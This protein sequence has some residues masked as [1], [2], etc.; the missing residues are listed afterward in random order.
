[1]SVYHSKLLE[2]LSIE[3]N[4][5]KSFLRVKY[6]FEIDIELL[7]EID[8]ETAM[9]LKESTDFSGKFKY[10]MSFHTSWNSNIQQH[11]S[12]ITRTYRDNS[13]KI[14][15]SCSDEYVRG[16][17]A[18][19]HSK[20]INQILNDKL[21]PA[22]NTEVKQEGE[23]HPKGKILNNRKHKVAWI[24]VA[25][26]IVISTILLG[27][28]NNS[29]FN[30]LSS[31]TP[32]LAE[33]V[34]KETIESLPKNEES[35]AKEEIKKNQ[36]IISE[37]PF[38]QLNDAITF[39]IPDGKVALTFDDGPSKYTTEIIDILKKHTVGGTFFFTGVNVKK[40]PEYVKYAQSNNYSIG[41]HS[42]YHKELTNLSLHNQEH[43][44]IQANLLIEELTNEPVTL[45]RPPYG[46]NNESTIELLEK[47]QH[48]MVLWNK[49]P[50]DWKVQSS[51]E[52]INY[53]RSSNPSG[54]IILLHESQAV[55]DALPSIISFL[56]DEG[57]EVVSLK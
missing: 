31:K 16:L 27:F 50:K 6:S 55:I 52:I 37:I 5:N 26:F 35:P 3:N 54:S 25:S 48:K 43:E 10:R 30:L 34:E 53:I 44:I 57:L 38:V 36:N 11:R 12:Y 9:S 14:Y 21:Q 8:T 17:N 2:L 22:R 40:Y 42:M 56:H 1:M 49:D 32:V 24:T 15:F 47:H 4:L 51:N 20:Q 45:F 39:S 28:S 18:F 13:E 7:W 41:S 29:Y 46:S 23:I 33:S 19:K